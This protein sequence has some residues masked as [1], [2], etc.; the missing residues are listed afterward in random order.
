MSGP[1]AA[2]AE[3]VMCGGSVSGGKRG[4]LGC[5][6]RST[7]PGWRC[8][9]CRQPRETVFAEI[10]RGVTHVGAAGGNCKQEKGSQPQAPALHSP[11]QVVP[12]VSTGFDSGVR[13]LSQR[14]PS[15][16]R[17]PLFVSHSGQPIAK[18]FRG[19]TNGCGRLPGGR[20]W[21]EQSPAAPFFLH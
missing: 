20:F 11:G 5:P 9:G 2:A 18:G 8:R 7:G 12:G 19:R 1:L 3:T 17:G 14:C 15:N 4:V 16:F 21:L 10:G 13:Q 6:G